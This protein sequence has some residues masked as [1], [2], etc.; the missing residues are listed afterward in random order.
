VIR[1]S[2][3]NA[4]RAFLCGDV[5]IRCLTVAGIDCCVL[6]KNHALD[7]RYG[8]LAETLE[9][10]HEAGMR[11]A[12]AGC[13]ETE[14]AASAVIELSAPRV[15]SRRPSIWHARRARIRTDLAASLGLA[16]TLEG[17]RWRHAAAA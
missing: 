8:G 13:D 10:L 16:N 14:A 2:H 12:G 5:M 4:V 7:R 15:C 1:A 6:A 3:P 11:S 17:P 9:T